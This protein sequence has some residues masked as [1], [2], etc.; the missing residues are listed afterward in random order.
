VVPVPVLVSVVELLAVT[1]IVTVLV[2]VLTLLP[3]TIVISTST[4]TSWSTVSS[5]YFASTNVPVLLVP[6]ALPPGLVAS[7]VQVLVLVLVEW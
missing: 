6:E 3:I 1:V 4:S 2:V 5:R 7:T